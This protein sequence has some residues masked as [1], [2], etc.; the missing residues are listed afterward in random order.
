MPA[1]GRRGRKLDPI[2]F[3]RPIRMSELR[4]GVLVVFFAENVWSTR[5]FIFSQE[6]LTDQKPFKEKTPVKFGRSSK[7]QIED[8]CKFSRSASNVK[9]GLSPR[10]EHVIMLEQSRVW[11][12]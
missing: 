8:V 11:H 1:S 9:R 3:K 12:N 10:H 7:Q 5:W 6:I 4:G 2:N